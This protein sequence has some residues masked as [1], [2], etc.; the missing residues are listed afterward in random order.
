MGGS[1]QAEWSPCTLIWDHKSK[2]VC[3]E[4]PGGESC[5]GGVARLRQGPV[6]RVPQA[7]LHQERRQRYLV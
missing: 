1:P 7:V 2:K 3:A 4:L 6:P 5:G